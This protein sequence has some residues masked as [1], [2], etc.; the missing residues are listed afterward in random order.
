MV[1]NLMYS[2]KEGTTRPNNYQPFNKR[3]VSVIKNTLLNLSSHYVK[4]LNHLNS[5]K[6]VI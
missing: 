6:T 3:S 1:M 5:V 4:L 2:T